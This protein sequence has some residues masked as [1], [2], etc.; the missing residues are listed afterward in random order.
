MEKENKY[1]SLLMNYRKEVF[2]E[3]KIYCKSRKINL[4]R[5]RKYKLL[6]SPHRGDGIIYHYSFFDVSEFNSIF[7]FIKND[8]RFSL[9]SRREFI[10]RMMKINWRFCLAFL[11]MDCYTQYKIARFFS[12]DSLGEVIKQFPYG[13]YH[14][15]E[16][17]CKLSTILGTD[18][19]IQLLIKY[20]LHE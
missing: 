4:D 10:E 13:L 3:F 8:K 2:N 19:D 18:E 5:S 17:F 1:Y 7:D 14:R 20:N 15:Y 6:F 16:I 11:K 9:K 12:K